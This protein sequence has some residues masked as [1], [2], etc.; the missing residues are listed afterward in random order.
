M[1]FA[2]VFGVLF[3]LALLF[4][5][6][7]AA[8]S[9]DVAIGVDLSKAP[10]IKFITTTQSYRQPG[11]DVT[12]IGKVLVVDSNGKSVSDASVTLKVQFPD[13]TTAAGAYT[14]YSNGYYQFDLSMPSQYKGKDVSVTASASASRGGS[15]TSINTI[16][17]MFGSTGVEYATPSPQPTKPAI[18]PIAPTKPGIV[19]PLTPEKISISYVW[20]SK[21]SESNM[22]Y[23][24]IV[25]Q[26]YG[27]VKDATVIASVS[28][29]LSMNQPMRYDSSYQH[30]IGKFPLL[31]GADSN[32]KVNIKAEKGSL[33][34]TY[35]NDV[36]F[37]GR[38]IV[39][40]QGKLTVADIFSDKSYVYAKVI[41]ANGNPAG[42]ASVKVS[43]VYLGKTMFAAYMDY[44][45][46]SGHFRYPTSGI[47]QSDTKATATVSAE[48]NGQ[49]AS[50]SKTVV[51]YGSGTI[52]L[53]ANPYISS[54]WA[55]RQYVYAKILDADGTPATPGE[56]VSAEVKIGFIATTGQNSPSGFTPIKAYMSYDSVS[57]YYKYPATGIVSQDTILPVDVSLY[58]NGQYLTTMEQSLQFYAQIT[59]P[60]GN[61]YDGAA[62]QWCPEG[63]RSFDNLEACDEYGNYPSSHVYQTGYYT[64]DSLPDIGANA[65]IS[66]GELVT[67]A[68][69]SNV[70]VSANVK[71][72]GTGR[73]ANWRTPWIEARYTT[74]EQNYKAYIGLD[75]YAYLSKAKGDTW[76]GD[77]VLR[78]GSNRYDPYQS[79]HITLEL[80]GSLVRVFVNG[81]LEV[82]YTDDSPFGAGHVVFRDYNGEAGEFSNIRIVDLGGVVN[83]ST[84]LKVAGITSDRNFVYAKVVDSDGTPALPEEG[85]SVSLL[86][87]WGSG[88]SE[89]RSSPYR[90]LGYVAYWPGKVNQHLSLTGSSWQ[91]D[92]D[93]VS[94]GDIYPVEY[95]QKYFP[96]S[97]GAYD[98]GHQYITGWKTRGNADN[99]NEKGVVYQCITE[100]VASFVT[101]LGRPM[102]WRHI[103][104][105]DMFGT[106]SCPP[107]I[108][109]S[110]NMVPP[111]GPGNS[112]GGSA[113]VSMS[114]DP[115]SGY[116]RYSTFGMFA[117]DTTV[118]ATAKASRATGNQEASLTQTITIYGSNSVYEI[119]ISDIWSDNSNGGSVYAKV[120]DSDGTTA[121]PEE[122]TQVVMT[123]QPQSTCPGG[124]I[125]PMPA[126]SRIA[127]SYDASTGYYK[128]STVGLYTLDT[129]VSATAIATKGS[130][131]ASLSKR[132][133][134]YGTQQPTAELTIVDIWSDNSNGGQIYA[135]VIKQDGTPATPTEGT[136]VNIRIKLTSGYGVVP[137]GS[138]PILNRDIKMGF[139]SESGY[140]EL[141]TKGFFKMDTGVE[142]TVT[143]Y[144]SSVANPATMTKIVIVY[145]SEQPPQ[146]PSGHT[147]ELYTGWNMISA[148]DDGL[149]LEGIKNACDVRSKLWYYD[150]AQY[151]QA[152]TTK[153]NPPSTPLVAG[154]GYW[155]KVAEGCKVDSEGKPFAATEIKLHKGWNQI[156]GLS[157]DAQYDKEASTCTITSGPWYYKPA[158][159]KRYVKSTLDNLGLGL[160]H[161][162]KAAQECTLA[163]GDGMP[164]APPTDNAATVTAQATIEQQ[165]MQ[166]QPAQQPMQ[167]QA[168]A[169]S[170][171]ALEALYLLNKEPHQWRIDYALTTSAGYPRSLP[172][173]EVYYSNS[174]YPRPLPVHIAYY[175][176][177][178]NEEKKTRIDMKYASGEEVREYDLAAKGLFSCTKSNGEWSCR[179]TNA[180]FSVQ[181]P[182]DVIGTLYQDRNSGKTV[183]DGT[184]Y[185][186]GT[187]AECFKTSDLETLYWTGKQH[188]QDNLHD[189]ILGRFCYSQQSAQM[190][191]DMKLIDGG[192]SEEAEMTATTYSLSVADSAFDLPDR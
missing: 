139:N 146:P 107:G 99:Y 151:Q 179:S 132:L 65:K 88:N 55:D 71:A 77:A 17:T 145:G 147:L 175:E 113:L 124:S 11:N 98:I 178:T 162:V 190:Y 91:T 73:T 12:T 170:G 176:K 21:T 181:L 42:K 120:L 191:L 187:S 68:E 27:L 64:D 112:Q 2:N 36:Y 165:P 188:S 161:W 58:K 86:M 96:G 90:A 76:I 3:V 168:E 103:C 1:K 26:N 183:T 141:P 13:G 92:P 63:S 121:L 102:Q 59:Q 94:G 114:Y 100:D 20:S 123:L 22:L 119:K 138:A 185:L 57:G 32:V 184:M 53:P 87:E 134:I 50:L 6:A 160:G 15:S 25:D 149:T 52:V 33:S 24:K 140:Y 189:G 136:S 40:P 108:T 81:N 117:T 148:P 46:S 106:L 186:A 72:I 150:G 49:M 182:I 166:Q 18:T 127:L 39:Q 152:P 43:A 118:R 38:G 163:F 51:I 157:S 144:K 125:C 4:G 133:T 110:D 9:K 5:S 172:V 171:P 97:H 109:P 10:I 80:R 44:D 67:R 79:N 177:K 105:P 34:T 143:A 85:T 122:G 131:S 153:R 62:F 158:P 93:G 142:A 28:G 156:G 164:P 69:Y 154:Q 111:A 30:Y 126:S 8:A 130:L 82:E 180:P 84:Q 173:R 95:C 155:I 116:Y 137:P 83:P 159:D 128:G 192:N 47:V 60:S 101:Y 169:S 54:L 135:K 115:A 167:V 78:H 56:G 70:Q 75:G 89:G 29:A 31:D 129:P 48:S 74:I 35:A 61:V 66:F 45:S 23:A 104:E 16:V 7:F 37:Y 174:Q 14:G 41:D 19:Q